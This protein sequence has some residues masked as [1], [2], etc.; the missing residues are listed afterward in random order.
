MAHLH[1]VGIRRNH[2]LFLDTRLWLGRLAQQEL[3]PVPVPLDGV[4]VGDIGTNRML[5]RVPEPM[6]AVD[7]PSVC[8]FGWRRLRP[9]QVLA[10]RPPEVQD[11]DTELHRDEQ[12]VGVADKAQAGMP[13]FTIHDG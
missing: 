5:R 7:A 3:M 4:V 1:R 13:R 12:L 11:S 10:A 2:D 8:G 6:P 9:K